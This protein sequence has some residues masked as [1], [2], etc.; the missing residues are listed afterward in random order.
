MSERKAFLEGK[1]KA[2]N[3]EKEQGVSISRLE[4]IDKE[5]S[6]HEAELQTINDAEIAQEQAAAQQVRIEEATAQAAY[7]LDNLVIEGFT[8]RELCVDEPQY[9]I[10]RI[11]VQ[12]KIINMA[13]EASKQIS[14]VQAEEYLQ[15]VLINLQ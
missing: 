7:F 12:N 14:V 2:L 11:A 4:V 8:M 10:L 9:Q 3:E 1:I 5:L 15:R 6:V 13:E